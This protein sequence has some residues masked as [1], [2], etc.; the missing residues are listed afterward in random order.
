MTLLRASEEIINQL[1]SLVQQFNNNEY[2]KPVDLL[3]SNSIGK[4]VRHIVEFYECLLKGLPTGLINYDARERNLRIETDVEYTIQIL[5]SIEAVFSNL[6]EDQLLKL[7]VSYAENSTAQVE[8]SLYR[9]LSYNIEHAV[10]HFAVIQIALKQG[11]EQ[12]QLPKNFGIAYST[13]KF[14]E[15]QKCAQ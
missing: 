8:T 13:V 5:S 4:H 9:E 1:K 12:I 15:S 10:H 7:E 6:K 3:S 14:Q 11:F 2:S